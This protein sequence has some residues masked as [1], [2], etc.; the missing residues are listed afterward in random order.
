M[1]RSTIVAIAVGAWGA[2]IIG[3]IIGMGEAGTTMGLVDFIT[4]G[5]LVAIAIGGGIS[6]RW[7]GPLL[8]AMAVTSAGAAAVG[9]VNGSAL[10]GAIGVLG[11]LM[12]GASVVIALRLGDQSVASGSLRGVETRLDQLQE[13]A[14][15][16]ESARRVLYRKRELDLLRS[17]IEDD[18]SRGD[19]NAALRLCD[20]MA[21]QFGF[22]EEAETYRG[23]IIQARRAN[24]EAQI[25][26]AL[27]SLDEHLAA[28][29]WPQAHGVAASLRRLFPESHV[30]LEL[31]ARILRA[32]DEHKHE[33]EHAFIDAAG[34]DDI[35]GA[36]E[37]LR[38][39][40]R[41]LGP[42][43]SD[44]LAETA[45][46]VVTKHRDNLGVQ[47]K[48]AVGDR[49]WVDAARIGDSIVT[50]FP[51]TRMAEEVAGMIDV[52]RTR[53]GGD[54]SPTSAVPAH[55]PVGQQVDASPA[56]GG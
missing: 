26:A 27:V 15:L 45:A 46:T 50:E 3:A 19:H 12:T 44:R 23:R 10:F 18:I 29:D 31:D 11:M 48:L 35:E 24:D 40:D 56:D 4:G 34:R 39:L 1:T 53:A 21:G 30:V 20:E 42:D 49:R 52:L 51:N 28:R 41:Y 37:C 17:A 47:F 55:A 43:D 8:G 54:S 36:Y 2:L 16:S 7:L 6:Q 38:N 13:V 9:A 25:R 14:M 32:R 33:L 5:A 22:R